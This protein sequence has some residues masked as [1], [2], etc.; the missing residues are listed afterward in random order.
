M[1]DKPYSE[2][3]N[4]ELLEEL[5]K[6]ELNAE[7]ATGWSSLYFAAKQIEIIIKE[8]DRRGISWANKYPIMRGICA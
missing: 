6:W 3:T 8:A 1:S 5:I 7:E 2:T 4:E